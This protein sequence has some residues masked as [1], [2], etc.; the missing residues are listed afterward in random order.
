M[1]PMTS[2]LK[3]FLGCLL[4]AV[5]IGCARSTPEPIFAGTNWL[6]LGKN[7]TLAYDQ[8][9]VNP[10]ELDQIQLNTGVFLSKIVWADSVEPFINALDSAEQDAVAHA[11]TRFHIETD[12]TNQSIQYSIVTM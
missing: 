12:S 11:L 2:R 8:D 7:L 9:Y 4:F 10:Y 1:N 5:F 6:P 3:M